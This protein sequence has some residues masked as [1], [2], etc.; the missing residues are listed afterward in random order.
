[1]TKWFWLVAIGVILGFIMFGQVIS[2]QLLTEY[3]Q[4]VR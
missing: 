2:D 4:A 3:F 1:M